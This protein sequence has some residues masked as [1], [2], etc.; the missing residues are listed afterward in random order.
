[1]RMHI[2][3][4]WNDLTKEK[5]KWILEAM[6]LKDDFIYNKENKDHCWS[7]QIACVT[8]KSKEFVS[9]EETANGSK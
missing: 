4:N 9:A 2:N 8:F 1:M 3:I 7:N 5:Q 6:E